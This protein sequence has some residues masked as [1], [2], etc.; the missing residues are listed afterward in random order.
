MCESAR[1]KWDTCRLS[2]GLAALASE[3]PR[4]IERTG[5]REDRSESRTQASKRDK[6]V[7]SL[8]CEIQA[9]SISLTATPPQPPTTEIC[10]LA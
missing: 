3:L 1:N 4:R 8:Y 6:G 5:R 10:S 9:T 7:S 2:T